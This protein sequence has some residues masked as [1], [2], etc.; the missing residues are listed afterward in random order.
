MLTSRAYCLPTCSRS[1]LWPRGLAGLDVL[2]LPLLFPMGS[3]LHRVLGGRT[4]HICH[5]QLHKTGHHRLTRVMNECHQVQELLSSKGGSPMV[6]TSSTAARAEHLIPNQETRSSLGN[7]QGSSWNSR[8]A[9]GWESQG[10]GSACVEQGQRL[11]HLYALSPS[12]T[13]I[14]G[15]GGV[16]I[17]C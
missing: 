17:W 12:P 5:T 10:L 3:S 6:T 11:Q 8:G 7:S 2:P 4:Q 15:Y 16:T 9:A 14:W 13:S 1:R